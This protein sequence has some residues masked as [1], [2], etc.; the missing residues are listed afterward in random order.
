[1]VNQANIPL[2]PAMSVDGG[3]LMVNKVNIPLCP[4]MSVDGS[5]LMVNQAN[6]PLCPAMSVNGCEFV[7]GS[8]LVGFV[9]EAP[10]KKRKPGRPK[11]FI[12]SGKA[13]TG[14]WN[15]SLGTNIHAR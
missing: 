9:E 15:I 11:K 8:G 14:E 3:V 4:A 1:M 6:I 10:V 2:C 12:L 13:E 5:E 7:A